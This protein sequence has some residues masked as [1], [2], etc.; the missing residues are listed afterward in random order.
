V[1]RRRSHDPVGAL[2]RRE[3]R[4]WRRRERAIVAAYHGDLATTLDGLV[5]APVLA[6]TTAPA[7]TVILA[8]PGWTVAVA[9]VSAAAQAAL[10]GAA[11]APCHVTGSGR[12]GP[13]WWLVV[14]TAAG[15]AVPP[16]V[17]LGAAVRLRRAGPE[18]PSPAPSG[19][20]P[21]QTRKEYSRP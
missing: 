2:R 8:V 16:A 5:G 4:A 1:T 3:R 18:P 11:R 21:R 15:P 13:F 17:V 14:A 12:Y 10:A 9:G 7:G 19:L 6:V 20:T